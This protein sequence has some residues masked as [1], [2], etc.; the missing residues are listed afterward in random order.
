[1]PEYI[2]PK[3]RG[4]YHYLTGAA[5]W[6]LLTMLTEVY[7]VKGRLGDLILQPKLVKEQ[8]DAA[9]NA[10]VTTV[11]A[12]KKLR[13]VYANPAWLDYGRY[14]LQQVTID[15]QPGSDFRSDRENQAL[16]PREFLAGLPQSECLITVVLG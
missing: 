15:D 14:R 16:I 1:M 8:F 11:F 4:M 5:S 12:G 2:N 9:G 10:A 3:G 6:L 13:V 7:G